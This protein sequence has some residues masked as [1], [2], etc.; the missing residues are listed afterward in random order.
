MADRMRSLLD[1]I[2]A[3]APADDRE[4]LH[5]LRFLDLL[6]SAEDCFT[7]YRFRPG[8]VTASAFIVD[9]AGER[10]LLHRHRRLERWL[11]MGGHVDDGERAVDA[12]LR[13]GMEESGL[14]D[15]HLLMPTLLDLDVHAIPP[16]R[17]EPGHLHF[18]VRYLLASATPDAVAMQEAESEELRW[19]AFD[20]AI[21]A[22][23]EEGSRRAIEKIV[24]VLR[25][26]G[27]R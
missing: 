21:A 14:A 26:G 12:A 15:L 8:H 3:C 27:A 25:D 5:R 10:L 2:E 4:K 18:D 22:M 16:G 11:Q 20:E 9:P 13:E 23:D 24:R 17:G 7:R 19:F 1:E 6:R